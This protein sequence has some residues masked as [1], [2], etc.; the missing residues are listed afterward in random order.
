M[1]CVFVATLQ[2]DVNTEDE[3]WEALA[4]YLEENADFIQGLDMWSLDEFE[5]EVDDYLDGINDDEML[6]GLKNLRDMSS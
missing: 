4:S 6:D 3:G 2:F 1:K 5:S